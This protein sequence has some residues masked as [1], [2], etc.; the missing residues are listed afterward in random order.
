M[1]TFMK[2]YDKHLRGSISGWDRISFRGTIRW[3]ANLAGMR[4]YLGYKNVLLKDF[5]D[6]AQEHTKRI[7]SACDQTAQSLN[8]ERR[9]LQSAS[10]NKEDLARQIAREAKIDSG[11]ICMFSVVEP[12]F[13]PTVCANQA[14]QKLELTMRHRR[15]VWTYYYWKDEALGFGHLRLQTWLPFTVKGNINGRE[16]LGRQ[17]DN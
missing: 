7:R 8:L 5:G 14:T 4:S 17:L 15:C 12:S 6:W 16:W 11:P 2:L 3:L 1:K 13:S 10:I 9:Y